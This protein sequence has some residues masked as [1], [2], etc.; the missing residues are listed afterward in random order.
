MQVSTAFGATPFG[1]FKTPQN[2]LS[3]IGHFDWDGY[4]SQSHN[5]AGAAVLEIGAKNE[6]LNGTLGYAFNSQQQLKIGIDYLLQKLAYQFDSGPVSEWMDQTAIGGVYRYVPTNSWVGSVFIKGYGA[7]SDSMN[8]SPVTTTQTTATAITTYTNYRRIAGANADG[9]GAGLDL[10]PWYG[11]QIQLAG[12]FDDVRYQTKYQPHVT[13]EGLGGTIDVTQAITPHIAIDAMGAVRKPFNTYRAGVNWL[14]PTKDGTV[15]LGLFGAITKGKEGLP[16]SSL[17]GI[18]VAYN[19]DDDKN[20]T[21]LPEKINH[22][23][24]NWTEKAAISMPQ[25]LAIPDQKT[26]VTQQQIS[27]LIPLVPVTPSI[28][29]ILPPVSRPI[30]EMTFDSSIPDTSSTPINFS[31]APYFSDPQNQRLFYTATGFYYLDLSIDLR[32]GVIKG[33]AP[34]DEY[35]TDYPI[36]VTAINGSGLESQPQTFTIK[37]KGYR[38]EY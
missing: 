25:V 17:T 32:T 37:I 11:A 29:L 28:P 34:A 15:K 8:L 23:L 5:L 3:T 26:V 6:R 21:L 4:L 36:T 24:S 1:D 19:W 20:A 30:P 18:N 33:F 12:N 31:I 35:T 2:Y 38:E 10:L 22:S 27:P 13:A 16:N 14:H 7:K 9:A